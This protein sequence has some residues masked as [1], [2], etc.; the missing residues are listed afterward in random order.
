MNNCPCG[1]GINY[2]NCCGIFHSGKQHAHTAEQLM[3]SR[4]SAFALKNASY[5]L[6]TEKLKVANSSFLLEEQLRET[7]WIKL[8]LLSTR[9]GLETD[10]SGEVQFRATYFN[11]G[12]MNQMTEHSL[13]KRINGKWM[14][15]GTKAPADFSS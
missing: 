1:S 12:R 3:R 4:Y 5:I 2:E 10:N 7:T 13:F 11:S 14:Y 6:Q 8:E 15:T 9:G